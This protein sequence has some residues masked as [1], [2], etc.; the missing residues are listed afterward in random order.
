MYIRQRVR[1]SLYISIHS[2]G[3]IVSYSDTKKL[4]PE[5]A[6]ASGRF[7]EDDGKRRPRKGTKVKIIGGITSAVLK[8]P[9]F[10]RNVRP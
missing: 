7:S 2:S 1:C 9:T 10:I 5:N 8:R 4:N 6:V 3:N